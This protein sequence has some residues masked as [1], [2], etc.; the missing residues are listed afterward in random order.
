MEIIEWVRENWIVISTV[1]TIASVVANATK[2]ESDNRMV[3]VLNKVL[4]VLAV[5]FNVKGVGNK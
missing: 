1:V 4:G 2:N 3:Q 5:N